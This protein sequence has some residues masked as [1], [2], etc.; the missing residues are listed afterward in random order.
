MSTTTTTARIY[1]EGKTYTRRIWDVTHYSIG[2]TLGRAQIK[3]E[4]WIVRREKKGQWV[5]ITRQVSSRSAER[6]EH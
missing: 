6:H 3:R 2:A 4:T 1:C 5:A